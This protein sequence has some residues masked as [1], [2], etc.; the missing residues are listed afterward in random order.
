MKHDFFQSVSQTYLEKENPSAPNR[1]KTYMYDLP[2]STLDALLLSY[3]RFVV[4]KPL[5]LQPW[6]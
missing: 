5:K 3:K 4:A 6:P 1:S 2:I